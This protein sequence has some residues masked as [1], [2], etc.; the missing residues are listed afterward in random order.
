MEGD[1]AA[2]TDVNN[3]SKSSCENI[4]LLIMCLAIWALYVVYACIDI[5]IKRICSN[6]QTTKKR[7]AG[8]EMSSEREGLQQCEH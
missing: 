2:P 5:R 3:D 7:L 6:E 4:R 1:M 8:T